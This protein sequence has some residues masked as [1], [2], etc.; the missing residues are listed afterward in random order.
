VNPSKAQRALR[1]R[2][3]QIYRYYGADWIS[4]ATNARDCI[5]NILTGI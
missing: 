3:W 4:R 5:P 2:L 1:R